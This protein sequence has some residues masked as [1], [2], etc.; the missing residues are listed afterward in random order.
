MATS[1][2]SGD[3]DEA[4][5]LAQ[6]G[7]EQQ[8]G[9]R[10]KE[11]SHSLGGRVRT[12]RRSEGVVDVEI[13]AVCELSRERRVVGRLTGIEAR[14]LEHTDP[15]VGQQLAQA[16]LDGGH[17]EIGIGAFRSAEMRTD[18]DAGRTPVEQ[19][20]KRRQRCPDARVVGHA[21]VFER[22]VQVGT[23][24]H[25]LVLDVR[26]P[27]RAGRPHGH[28]ALIQNDGRSTSREPFEPAPITAASARDRPADELYPHSLSYQEKTLTSFPC[29]IVSPES[30]MDE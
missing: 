13:H 7:L 9:V 27:D 23:D 5:E 6:L 2:R 26:F 19:Q 24:E 15:I 30:K 25:P 17:T 16:R 21:A 18:R 28:T 29:A 20:P 8:A 1:G 11:V 4:T 10:R 22:D 12:V 14:V 3:V